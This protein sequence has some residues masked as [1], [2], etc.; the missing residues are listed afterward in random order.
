MDRFQRY[1]EANGRE[2]Q[3]EGYEKDQERPA[4]WVPKRF[5]W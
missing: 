2:G 1:A 5:Q 3:A 4:D